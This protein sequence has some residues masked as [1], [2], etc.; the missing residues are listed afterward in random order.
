MFDLPLHVAA[1]LA[2]LAVNAEPPAGC[3]PR[4]E[5]LSQ[6]AERYREAPVAI[7]L[8]SNGGLIELLT[9]DTGTTWTL[10][11]TAPNGSSCVLAEGEDWQPRP[12]ARLDGQDA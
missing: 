12:R 10:I 11:I 4:D 3:G 6:L 7:G 5:V 8:A 2:V 1:A 9:A